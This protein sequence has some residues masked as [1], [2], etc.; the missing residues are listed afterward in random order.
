MGYGWWGWCGRLSVVISTL[1]GFCV[2]IALVYGYLLPARDSLLLGGFVGDADY[3]R[4]YDTRTGHYMSLHRLVPYINAVVPCANGDLI[5]ESHSVAEGGVLYRWRSGRLIQRYPLREGLFLVRQSSKATCDRRGRL[6]VPS[7][8]SE[9]FT[10]FVTVWD[11]GHLRT[12]YIDATLPDALTIPA[13]VPGMFLLEHGHS[14]HGDWIGLQQ[15]YDAGDWT[16]IV[17]WDGTRVTFTSPSIPAGYNSW[18]A[19]WLPW[20]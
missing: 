2:G 18:T 4:L 7:A 11:G 12:L 8:W 13:T 1:C 3:F 6:L 19:V 9:R 17:V 20:P 14:R 5:I 10:S 15:G 16:R